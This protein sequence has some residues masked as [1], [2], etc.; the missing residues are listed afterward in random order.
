MSDASASSALCILA[1]EATLHTGKR[2]MPRDAKPVLVIG[3]LNMD[4][5]A[6]C[7]LYC[8]APARRCSD[9]N[10]CSNIHP[11]KIAAATRFDD[12]L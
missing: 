1:R 8:P 5:V 11:D 2:A 6:G 10:F 4:L 7:E 3:S 9:A 12:C